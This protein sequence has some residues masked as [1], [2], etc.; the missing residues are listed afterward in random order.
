MFLHI[1]PSRLMRAGSMRFTPSTFTS[2]FMSMTCL[3]FESQY[4]RTMFAPLMPIQIPL[5]LFRLPREM[6][7]PTLFLIILSF[8]FGHL[9]AV[10]RTR[11]VP[12]TPFLGLARLTMRLG[13]AGVGIVMIPASGFLSARASKI[14]SFRLSHSSWLNA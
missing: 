2:I 5:A 12:T 3:S 14:S 9:P 7:F 6:P 11:C 1:E 10:D 13:N 4:R 8:F